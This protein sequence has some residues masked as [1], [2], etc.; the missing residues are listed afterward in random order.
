MGKRYTRTDSTSDAGAMERTPT[1]NR[2]IRADDIRP[3][4]WSE[5]VRFASAQVPLGRLGGGRDIG[6]NLVTLPP[7]KQSC[8]YHW[9]V[10]EE[11]HF[12]ILEGACVLRAGDQRHPMTAGDYVCF[13]ANTRIGHC[14]ENPFDEP[15]RFLAVGNRHPQEIAVYP[16]SGKMKL[17]AL[18]QIVPWSETSLDYWQGERPERPLD[19]E[20]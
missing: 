20:S 7:G 5:G 17:R 4:E 15:C 18:Q 2:P 19:D 9:H 14:F 10:R 6:V 16:D 12:Y 1:P 3:D 13:P 8:P 11:E